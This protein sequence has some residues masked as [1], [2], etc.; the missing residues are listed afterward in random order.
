MS[1]QIF[2]TD[3]NEPI[4]NIN[5]TPFV[6]IILVVLIIF[7]VTT[8]MIV[9]PSLEVQLPKAVSSYDSHPFPLTITLNQEGQIDLNGQTI[10]QEQLPQRVR[11]MSQSNPELQA[12]ISA[13]K[14]VAHGHVITIIDIVRNAGISKFAIT[15][16]Q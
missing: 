7:M 3:E 14:D 2:T 12:V 4:A 16:S 9:K 1:G 13:D 5:V 11:A 15:T 6:D 10:T 8:P